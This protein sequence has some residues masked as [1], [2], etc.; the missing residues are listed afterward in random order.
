M[1]GKRKEREIAINV[2]KVTLL[3][4]L[5]LEILQVYVLSVLTKV[6]L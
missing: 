3:Y 5:P 2:G 1:G 4:F 6:I